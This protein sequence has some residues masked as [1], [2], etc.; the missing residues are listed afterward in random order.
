MTFKNSTYFHLH[1]LLSNVQLSDFFTDLKQ[2][3]P[4]QASIKLFGEFILPPLSQYAYVSKKHL[5]FVRQNYTTNKQYKIYHILFHHDISI[6]QQKSF[7]HSLSTSLS[8][9]KNSS[10]RIKA[11]HHQSLHFMPVSIKMI[12]KFTF[13]FFNVYFNSYKMSYSTCNS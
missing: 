13:A 9:N 3:L 6:L 1:H 11:Q 8:F 5:K 10:L 12:C 4:F 2:Q 7:F